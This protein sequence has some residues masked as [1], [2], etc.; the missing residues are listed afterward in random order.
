MAKYKTNAF[1]II[2]RE[3][4]IGGTIYDAE[5][6]QIVILD[7]NYD[8]SVRCMYVSDGVKKYKIRV[9]EY[10][11]FEFDGKLSNNRVLPGIS[12]RFKNK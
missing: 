7:L 5:G 12:N 6:N 4:L 1:E 11:D 8:P 2:L 9:D 10:F 3:N